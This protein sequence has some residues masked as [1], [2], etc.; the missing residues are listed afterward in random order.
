MLFNSYIFVCG[1]LSRKYISIKGFLFYSLY[2]YI[3]LYTYAMCINYLFIL[4]N[5]VY[6]SKINI[7]HSFIQTEIVYY[8]YIQYYQTLIHVII[9][10]TPLTHLNSGYL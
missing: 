4:Y 3:I 5:I 2:N 10:R 9:Y 7:I 1:I 8:I 6:T